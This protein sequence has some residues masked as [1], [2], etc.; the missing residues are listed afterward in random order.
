MYSRTYE[1][2]LFPKPGCDESVRSVPLCVPL[3]QY[4]PIHGCK[5]PD[6]GVDASGN[7]GAFRT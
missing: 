4:S 1:S 5:T 6:T 7:Q 3:A 2:H